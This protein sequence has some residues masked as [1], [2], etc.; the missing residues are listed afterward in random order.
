MGK[1]GLPAWRLEAATVADAD[2]RIVTRSWDS[3]VNCKYDTRTLPAKLA[4]SNGERGCA[5]SHAIL[6]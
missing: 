4:M 6:W 2:S 1:E 5:M 3:S